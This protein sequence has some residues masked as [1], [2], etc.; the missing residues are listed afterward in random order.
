VVKLLSPYNALLRQLGDYNKPIDN[1]NWETYN[2]RFFDN[3][4]LNELSLED[5]KKEAAFIQKNITDEVIEEAFGHFPSK[6]YKLTG[7]EI[8]TALKERRT[9]L[10]NI[11]EGFYR[12]LSK[13][14]LVVGSEKREYFEV[15]RQD[16]ANTL[17]NMYASS[18][19]G[20]KKN[21]LYQRLFKT[22][23]TK[24]IYLYGLGG[25]DIFHISG[26]VEKGI[27][28]Q[29]V[30]G[31]GEDEFI[32]V[33][34]VK[35]FFKKD[36]FYDSE[37]GNKLQLNTE[38]KDLT[39]NMAHHNIYDRLGTQHDQN[40]FFPFPQTS[41][42]ADDGFLLGFSG[43]YHTT[44]FNKIPFSQKHSFGIN[45]AFATKGIDFVYNGVFI[46]ASRNWD[47]VVNTE[48]RNS[49]YAFNFFGLGNES[50]QLVDDID[51][52]RV[53]QSLTYLDIGWQRRFA[54]DIGQFSI[55]PLVQSTQIENTLGRFISGDDNGLSAID[56]DRRW[57]GGIASS[58]NFSSVD[59]EVSPRFGFRYESNVG[60]QTSLNTGD[61]QFVTFDTGFTLYKSF[62]NRVK[63]I[64]ASKI[65]T[66]LIRGEYDF[67]FAPTLGQ[68]ENIRG[69]FSE[70]FRGET[71]FYHTSDLRQELGS[72]NNAILPFSF[73]VTASFDYGRIWDG[74]NS[75]IWHR[76]FGGGIWIVPLNIAV[77][78]FSYNKSD[79]DTRFR[80]GLGHAF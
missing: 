20:K 74:G 57:F 78:T 33:S 1:F 58:V 55:R 69:L 19:K 17:V 63:T 6:V 31:L 67:F 27:K 8:I 24:E 34:K 14:V 62:G 9:Q 59:N 56:F 54:G 47:F 12:H 28:V 37:K 35:G 39:S 45:Y 52:Y 30:G 73:G 79:V 25:D 13:K 64:F 53:R 7:Q 32:D 61:K 68:E 16:E 76:S 41:F 66:A 40:T 42:N 72:S 43:I 38:G 21:L 23:E 46:E 51:F 26:E 29:V 48:L 75:N 15:I 71:S 5:W 36:R 10:T 22:S 44:G 18:K 2:S 65:G 77:I 70:R 50:V 4:F 3:T 11:A 80:V 49:R 60:L